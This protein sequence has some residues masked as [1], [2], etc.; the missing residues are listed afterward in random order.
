MPCEQHSVH[1]PL[2]ESSHISLIFFFFFF[3][4]LATHSKRETRMY[5]IIIFPLYKLVSFFLCVRVCVG[6]SLALSRLFICSF[7]HS[8]EARFLYTCFLFVF[9]FG[10]LQV[11]KNLIK[12]NSC[13][14]NLMSHSFG[15]SRTYCSLRTQQQ[16]Q[17]HKRMN[18]KQRHLY[19]CVYMP[20]CV[21]MC[22]R[23]RK[24]FFIPCHYILS[25]EQNS[26]SSFVYFVRH[27]S[28]QMNASR[29]RTR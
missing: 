23:V 21:C 19:S 16:Q 9:L 6:C 22:V 2:K 17:Q 24:L 13:R 14:S 4:F 20:M 5:F 26:R 28:V 15:D 1:P 8:F 25:N 12:S 18:A 10:W 3:V 29:I 7:R 27:E 11:K